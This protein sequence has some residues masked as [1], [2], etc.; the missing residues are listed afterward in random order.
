MDLLDVYSGLERLDTTG[1]II[2]R[3]NKD[4]EELEYNNAIQLDTFYTLRY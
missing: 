2:Q 1:I 4:T 3:I